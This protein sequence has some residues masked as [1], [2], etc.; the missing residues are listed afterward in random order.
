ML[1]SSITCRIAVGPHQV[2]KVFAMQTLPGCEE[3]FDH[4][5]GKLA[6]FSL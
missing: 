5:V 2:R 1:D 6:G 4:G 3:P